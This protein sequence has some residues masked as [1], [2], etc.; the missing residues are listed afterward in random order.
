[1]RTLPDLGVRNRIAEY[2]R[3]VDGSEF[4]LNSIP[5]Y[6]NVVRQKMPYKVQNALRQNGC[7]ATFS[8][9][10][11]GAIPAMIP[12]ECPLELS[13]DELSRAIMVLHDAKLDSE[14]TGALANIDVK[15]TLMKAWIERAQSLN[16]YLEEANR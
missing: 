2:Y 9:N 3:V 4:Y 14:L 12:R 10:T 16:D 6:V 7:N 11:D 15:L 8:M 13:Q 1:M 5:A